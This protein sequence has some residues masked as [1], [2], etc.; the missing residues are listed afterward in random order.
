MV[1]HSGTSRAKGEPAA[2][3][4]VLSTASHVI[5]F[6]ARTVCSGTIAS[7]C[8]RRADFGTGATSGMGAGAV[9]ASEPSAGTRP[10]DSSSSASLPRRGW[11]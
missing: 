2:K 3:A 11:S 4:M 5:H 9:P 10:R 1:A 8:R 7:A 6:A